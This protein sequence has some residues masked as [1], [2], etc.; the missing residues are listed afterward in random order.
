[1]L[2]LAVLATLSVL[3]SEMPRLV[4]WPLMVIVILHAGLQVRRK[5]E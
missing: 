1:M 4:A 5:A 2:S 3:A